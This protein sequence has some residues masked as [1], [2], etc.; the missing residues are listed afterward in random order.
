M[1]TE[2]A[3]IDVSALR[4]IA[5]EF[6]ASAGDLD[7]AVRTRLSG[8]RFGG[9]TAGRAYVARGDALRSSLDGIADELTAWARA[10]A[11]IAAALRASADRYELADE[12]AAARLG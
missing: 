6:D 11:E 2:S 9:A 4:D 1:G 10:S 7:A 8:L 12:R 5:S 3:R